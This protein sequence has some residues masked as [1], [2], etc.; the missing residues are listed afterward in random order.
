MVKNVQELPERQSEL[1]VRVCPGT[2]PQLRRAHWS[3]DPKKRCG[4]RRSRKAIWT[5]GGLELQKKCCSMVRNAT[6][7]EALEQDAAS[8]KARR[9]RV[10]H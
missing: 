3:R 2:T 7:V 5:T 1:L 6:A 10:V 8:P 9:K 4:H